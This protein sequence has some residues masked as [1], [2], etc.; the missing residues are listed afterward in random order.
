M[1]W[2]QGEGEVILNSGIGSQHTMF[3]FGFGLSLPFNKYLVVRL[4][5]DH[6]DWVPGYYLKISYEKCS[7]NLIFF[8]F[9]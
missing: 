9:F 6:C 3:F 8:N 7:K 5:Y 2:T 4:D 1:E